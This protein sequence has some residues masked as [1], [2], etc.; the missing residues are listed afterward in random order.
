MEAP[1]IQYRKPT[2]ILKSLQVSSTTFT[3]VCS[4]SQ[5]FS[6]MQGVVKELI[7][8]S[9]ELPPALQEPRRCAGSAHL[10]TRMRER[11]WPSRPSRTGANSARATHWNDS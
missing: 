10:M 4:L 3:Q 1:K 5:L 9:K 11:T 8:E 6:V 7:F 2:S